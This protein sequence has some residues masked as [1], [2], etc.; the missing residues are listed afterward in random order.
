MSTLSDKKL[1]SWDRYTKRE[2]ERHTYTDESECAETHKE[3]QTQI[4]THTKTHRESDPHS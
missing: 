2:T 4:Q 1:L 3:T